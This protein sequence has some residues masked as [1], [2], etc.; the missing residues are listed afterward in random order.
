MAVKPGC[1]DV[2]RSRITQN[3]NMVLTPLLDKRTEQNTDQDQD[4]ACPSKALK[5]NHIN[6]LSN[7]THLL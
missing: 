3:N 1:Q 7:A 5:M 4:T 6:N 2:L